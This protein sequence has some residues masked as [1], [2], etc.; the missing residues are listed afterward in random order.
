MC[1]R[2][3]R[4]RG[5]HHQLTLTVNQVVAYIF[6]SRT[7][8][9]IDITQHR[10]ISWMVWLTLG[11]SGET[12]TCPLGRESFVPVSPSA[13]HRPCRRTGYLEPPGG[14]SRGGSGTGRAVG[15]WAGRGQPCL[16][17]CHPLCHRSHCYLGIPSWAA[18]TIPSGLPGLPSLLTSKSGVGAWGGWTPGHWKQ[19]LF[20]C[21]PDT[22]SQITSPCCRLSS[23]A[24]KFYF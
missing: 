19:G 10:P 4:R 18:K 16:L 9:G 23:A 3:Q 1:P 22:T 15:L 17:S 11:S 7:E 2:L 5:L 24:E 21:S 13:E 6:Y 12:N 8:Q 20:A 14:A